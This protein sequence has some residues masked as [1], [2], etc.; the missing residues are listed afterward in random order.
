V[1]WRRTDDGSDPNRASLERGESREL[2]PG[3][4]LHFPE[5]P[6]DIHSQQGIGGPAWELVFFGRN[7]N[8]RPRAYFDPETGL[9]QLDRAD[10]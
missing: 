3:D 2:G 9:V 6:G 4:V 5:P 1:G 10:R 7:P 8:A